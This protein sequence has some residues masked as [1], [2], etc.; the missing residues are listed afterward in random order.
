[1]TTIC[2]PDCRWSLVTYLVSWVADGQDASI[3]GD[4]TVR[5]L[6]LIFQDHSVEMGQ[7][8]NR[9]S[10][11][12]CAKTVARETAYETEEVNSFSILLERS[13]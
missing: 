3:L 4:W 5:Y 13:N 2:S 8:H 11:H 12:S 6:T 7:E 1:M 10:P 9:P